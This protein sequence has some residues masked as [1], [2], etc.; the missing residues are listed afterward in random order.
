MPNAMLSISSAWL[1]SLE[2]LDLCCLCQLL[3]KKP[4][5][6]VDIARKEFPDGEKCMALHCNE[7][8]GPQTAATMKLS[9]FVQ[10]KST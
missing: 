7:N 10:V 2:D 4:K 5:L 9:H 8:L 3:A 1:T 6:R